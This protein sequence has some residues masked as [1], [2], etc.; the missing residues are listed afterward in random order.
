MK[1]CSG[2]MTTR[3]RVTAPNSQSRQKPAASQAPSPPCVWVSINILTLGQLGGTRHHS[4]VDGTQG[5]FLRDQSHCPSKVLQHTMFSE[6]PGSTKHCDPIGEH[7]SL[8]L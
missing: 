5:T 2:L 6:D 1:M 8:S 7:I 3:D 4:A